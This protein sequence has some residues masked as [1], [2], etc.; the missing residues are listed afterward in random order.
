MHVHAVGIIGNID[1]VRPGRG[2]IATVA[3]L[4]VVC[5]LRPCSVKIASP[6]F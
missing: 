3:D 4:R 1:P 5:F 2:F 6:S